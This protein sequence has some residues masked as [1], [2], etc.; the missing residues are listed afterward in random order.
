MYVE[1]FKF[2]TPAHKESNKCMCLA[3]TTKNTAKENQTEKTS[4]KYRRNTLVAPKKE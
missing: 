4:I 1:P 3:R 2:L